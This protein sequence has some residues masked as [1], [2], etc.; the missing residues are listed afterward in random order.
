MY[1]LRFALFGSAF[2]ILNSPLA[3]AQTWVTIPDAKLVSALQDIIPAAIIGDQLNT[4][5]PVVTGTYSL[6]VGG[7][8]ITN[9]YGIQFFTSLT[10]LE[11]QNNGL[12]TLPPLPPTLLELYCNSNQLS[13]LPTLPTSLTVLDCSSNEI[14]ILPALPATLK[15]LTCFK[16]KLTALPEL[17][18][19]LTDLLC[20]NNKI[21]CLPILP[22]SI[23]TIEISKNLFT[24]IPNYV[25]SMADDTANYS[26]CTPGNK[27]GCVVVKGKK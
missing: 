1:S 6:D 22:N 16:N 7:H 25:K 12:L 17:P 11:C 26:L 5:S 4:E 18:K 3:S 19:S 13:S 10:Y 15:N 23:T 8:G 24:C 27:N 21:Q 2:L 14:T 9:L 20:Y